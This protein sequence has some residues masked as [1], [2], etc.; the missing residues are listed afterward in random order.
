MDELTEEH[1]VLP[2]GQVNEGRRVEWTVT[3]KRKL[4]ILGRHP[5]IVRI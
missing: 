4:R 3:K 1:D 2:L 5:P